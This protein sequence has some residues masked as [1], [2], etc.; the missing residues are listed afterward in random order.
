[1]FGVC[2]CKSY[3]WVQFFS[4]FEC[5]PGSYRTV[6]QPSSSLVKTG[7]LA[8]KPYDSPRSDSTLAGSLVGTLKP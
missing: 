2:G 7:N 1:M 4:E 5:L 3:E 6:W 8:R